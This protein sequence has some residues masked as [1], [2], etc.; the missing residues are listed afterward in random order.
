MPSAMASRDPFRPAFSPRRPSNFS[1]ASAATSPRASPCPSH[2]SAAP[3]ASSYSRSSSVRSCSSATSTCSSYSN[4]STSSADWAAQSP[5]LS[6]SAAGPIP[7]SDA[8]LVFRS[9]VDTIVATRAAA[10][11]AGMGGG[12]RGCGLSRSRSGRRDGSAGS[13]SLL[14]GTCN[15]PCCRPLCFFAP[16]MLPPLPSRLYI[17]TGAAAI[18]PPSTT[19]APPGALFAPTT[20]S[21]F[22]P[23]APWLAADDA[24]LGALEV[25]SLGVLLYSLLTGRQPFLGRS[26]ADTLRKIRAARVRFP[27]TVRAI[28]L[29]G[30]A[31][32]LIREMLAPDPA[33]RPTLQ[34]VL[35]H[36]WLA[37]PPARC[38]TLERPGF[39]LRKA[40]RIALSRGLLSCLRVD[41][42][43][44]DSE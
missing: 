15:E 44:S 37:S 26:N 6:H 16:E 28:V 14:F 43:V 29:P 22:A 25:W 23:S 3:S 12:A 24:A 36:P 10:T 5:M 41:D 9:L 39:R 35:A 31:K 17:E 38:R 33:S 4:S 2:H 1:G 13:S 7:E 19:A 18:I 8:R 32:R 34:Q 11:S 21:R 42:A 40:P 27:L 30:D 20:F